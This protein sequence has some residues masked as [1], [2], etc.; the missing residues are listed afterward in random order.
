VRPENAGALPHCKVAYL[1]TFRPSCDYICI[2]IHVVY[3]GMGGV[4]V[5]GVGGC[6]CVCV[7]VCRCI[8]EMMS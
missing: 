4:R 7:C 6:G 2:H 1:K 3:G 5:C 8:V